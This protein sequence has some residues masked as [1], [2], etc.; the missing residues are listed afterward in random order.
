MK[1]IETI[2][3]CTKRANMQPKKQ[4]PGPRE[5][6]SPDRPGERGVLGPMGPHVTGGRVGELLL[7]FHTSTL[8]QQRQ[9]EGGAHTHTHLLEQRP[10]SSWEK[11]HTICL[12]HRQVAISSGCVQQ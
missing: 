3:V 12:G 8:G 7:K 10:A 6:T 11:G 9:E 5:N 1:T 2:Q 4:K